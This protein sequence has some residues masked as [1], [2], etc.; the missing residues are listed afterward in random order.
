MDVHH[1][2]VGARGDQEMVLGIHGA[3]VTGSCETDV[4]VG[5]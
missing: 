4:G 1:L 2:N 5:N 3:E